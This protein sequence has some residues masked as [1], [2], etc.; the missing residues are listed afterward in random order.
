MLDRFNSQPEHPDA[1]IPIP[2]K[3]AMIVQTPS[4]GDMP[5]Q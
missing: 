5:S 3:A 4:I 2:I 1:S